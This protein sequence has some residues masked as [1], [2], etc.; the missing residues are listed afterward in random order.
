MHIEVYTPHDTEVSEYRNIYKY[1]SFRSFIE[2]FIKK[3]NLYRYYYIFMYCIIY[4]T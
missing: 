1:L 4:N 2:I 3:Y